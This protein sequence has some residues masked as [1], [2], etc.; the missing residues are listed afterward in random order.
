MTGLTASIL[1]RASR[2]EWDLGKSIEGMDCHIDNKLDIKNW[3]VREV[4][5]HI[6]EDPEGG[7]PKA[8]KSIING[9]LPELTIVADETHLTSERQ[10]MKL[11]A[12][13]Q[14]IRGYFR[15]LEEILSGVTDVQISRI[16]TS[17]W[18]PVR[19]YREDRTSQALLEGLFLRHWNEHVKQLESLQLAFSSP[20]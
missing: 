18:F 1:R 8:V 15:S 6:L 13:R 10:A 7:M 20:G 12:I 9:T 11:P 4:L 16:T 17:C 3:S 19:N 2:L 5:W 14:E